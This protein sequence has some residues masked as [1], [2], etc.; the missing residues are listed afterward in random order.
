MRHVALSLEREFV[1]PVCREHTPWHQDIMPRIA[2][3]FAVGRPS[4][5]ETRPDAPETLPQRDPLLAAL[6]HLFPDRHHHRLV[7]VPAEIQIGIAL[8]HEAVKDL[9]HRALRPRPPG[10]VT[11]RNLE[12][13]VLAEVNVNELATSTIWNLQERRQQLPEVARSEEHT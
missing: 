9:R 5:Q 12:R 6:P 1:L 3:D 10:T 13:L 4:F 2:R 8:L 11:Q 7:D